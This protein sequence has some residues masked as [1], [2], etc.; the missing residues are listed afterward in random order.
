M[1]TVDK[2]GQSTVQYIELEKYRNYFAP[3]GTGTAVETLA[4]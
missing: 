4:S 3:A 1:S 2:V